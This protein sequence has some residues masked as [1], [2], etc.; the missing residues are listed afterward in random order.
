M[1]HGLPAKE[2]RKLAYEYALACKSLCILSA[3]ERKQSATKEWYYAVRIHGSPPTAD[4]EGFGRNV[5]C[6]EWIFSY[7]HLVCK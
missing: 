2:L 4:S 5:H 6:D 7:W 1:F 3:W